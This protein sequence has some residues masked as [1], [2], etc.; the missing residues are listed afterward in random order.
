MAGAI[1]LCEYARMKPQD[2]KT[3]PHPE[4]AVDGNPAYPSLD[5]REKIVEENKKHPEEVKKIPADLIKDYP[6]DKQ[7]A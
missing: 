5:E 1:A 2:E 4:P 7:R 3:T 6:P